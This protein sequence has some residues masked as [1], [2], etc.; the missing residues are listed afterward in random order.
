MPNEDASAPSR[1][2]GPLF[3]D[4]NSHRLLELVIDVE[5]N[6]VF[7]FGPAIRRAPEGETRV[8]IRRR[9]YAFGFVDDEIRFD[10]VPNVFRNPR[11]PNPRAFGQSPAAPPH[12]N[13]FGI[14]FELCLRS[15]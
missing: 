6:P 3:D 7:S 4:R 8:C 2:R 13:I 11:Y 9:R 1:D 5:L 10:Q 12:I 14:R 15:P